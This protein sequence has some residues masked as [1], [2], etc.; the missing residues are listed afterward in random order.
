MIKYI[1]ILILPQLLFS[2]N[3]PLSTP[4]LP[5]GDGF[6]RDQIRVMFGIGQNFQTGQF[7]EPIEICD[8][9]FDGGVGT[10]YTI[11]VDYEREIFE[12]LFWGAGLR[13]E[14]YSFQSRFIDYRR[15]TAYP[16]GV[17]DDS[18]F[19]PIVIPVQFEQLGNFSMNSIGFNPYLRISPFNSVMLRAGLNFSYL[20]SSNFEHQE[21]LLSNV[22]GDGKYIVTASQNGL[23]DP[24][25]YDAELPGVESLMIYT[26][27][28]ISF[29]LK[30]PNNYSIAPG[31][32]YSLPINGSFSSFG[33]SK[34]GLWRM[35][36]EIKIP[37][38]APPA[39]EIE[40][41]LF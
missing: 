38:T 41:P 40:K 20:Y 17:P 3:E 12:F 14:N 32:E 6:S 18:E 2:Q 26:N 27:L 9:I 34:V 19:E 8:C 16:I 10:G 11:A 28:A 30:L 1:L 22:V 35:F 31:F 21:I 33:N 37:L 7:E 24:T 29:P 23:E 4:I 36:F 13:F 25:I 39:E 15:V 5:L